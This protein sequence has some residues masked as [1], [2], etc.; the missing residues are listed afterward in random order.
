MAAASRREI[1]ANKETCCTL[2]FFRLVWISCNCASACLEGHWRVWSYKYWTGCWMQTWNFLRGPTVG[3][4]VNIDRLL[5][6]LLHGGDQCSVEALLSWSW[7]ILTHRTLNLLFV[8]VQ[9]CHHSHHSQ[10]PE[11]SHH[12][13]NWNLSSSLNQAVIRNASVIKI[14]G[15][16]CWFTKAADSSPQHFHQSE[17]EKQVWCVPIFVTLLTWKMCLCKR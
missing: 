10:V 2:L 3:I 17:R 1:G 14:V 4:R 9:N 12:S 7:M 8:E 15:Y 13:W 5:Q 6:S 11:V 16:C